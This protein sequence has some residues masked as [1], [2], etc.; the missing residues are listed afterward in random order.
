MPARQPAALLELTNMGKRYGATRALDGASLS[1]AARQM[2]GLLG[3]NGAGKSTLIAIAAG[4]LTADRGSRTCA[5]NV[6]I[7]YLPQ[8]HALYPQLTAAENLAFVARICGITSSRVRDEVMTSLA[9]V[10]LVERADA[11]AG[12]F[13]GGMKRRLGFAAATLGRPHVLLLD[14][15]TAGVDPQSRAVLIELI[16]AER[17]RG[18]A[19]LYST[20]LMEEVQAHAD[21]VMILHEGRVLDRGTVAALLRR[22]SSA[23][24]ELETT[25]SDVDRLLPELVVTPRLANPSRLPAPWSTRDRVRLRVEATEPPSALRAAFRAADRCGATITDMRL[26]EPTLESVFLTLTGRGLK[27]R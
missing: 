13:S 12:G 21:E 16:R 1:L 14:E 3:P 11:R 5:A 10:G 27:D 18:A 7:G 24:V 6:R 23:Y 2:T 22:H 19:I 20:H 4:I 8:E 25:E 15:P 17:D 26:V 9:A